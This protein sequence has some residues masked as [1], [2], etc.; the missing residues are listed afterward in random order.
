[1]LLGLFAVGLAATIWW[2]LAGRPTDVSVTSQGA[3]NT[4]PPLPR[5]TALFRSDDPTVWD[6]DSPGER[7][8]IPLRR[9]PKQIRFV[10]LRR[11]DTEQGLILPLLRADLDTVL[12]PTREREYRW[13]GTNH[14]EWDAR[15]LGIVEG[16]RCKFPAPGGMMVVGHEGWDAWTGSGFGHK[17]QESPGKQ[18]YC[19]RGKELRRTVFEIAVT[20]D[21]V[22]A[23]EQNCLLEGP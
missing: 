15:H 11:M 23:D 13:N 14:F 12:L 5:W 16:P 20:N 7:F 9:A 4:G 8:A 1:V 22:T 6:S 21:P 10:R 2:A 19:W 17:C 18:H 3:E